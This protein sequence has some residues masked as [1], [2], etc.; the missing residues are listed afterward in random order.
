MIGSHIPRNNFD[1][2]YIESNRKRRS[3][4]RTNFNLDPLETVPETMT[5]LF[6]KREIVLVESDKK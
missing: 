5:P 3:L 1:I 4:N 2:N 6:K